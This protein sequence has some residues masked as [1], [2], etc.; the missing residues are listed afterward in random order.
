MAFSFNQIMFNIQRGYYRYIGSGTGRSV[1]DLGNGYVIKVAR[2]TAGIAQNLS[3]CEISLNDHS[4]LFAK[5]V[6]VSND[7]KLIIMQKADKLSNI[8]YVWN[9]YNVKN[10]LELLSLPGIRNAIRKYN[11]LFGDLDRASSWGLIN[12]R[13]V[14]IDYGFTREVKNGFYQSI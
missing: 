6:Q 9:Y 8:S 2:N 4:N 5:V 7:F 12:G 11:L 14:I 13:P 1:F 3:E 10:K